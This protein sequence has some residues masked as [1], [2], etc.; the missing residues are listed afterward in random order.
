MEIGV[1]VFDVGGFEVG[2]SVGGLG[3]ETVGCV[4]LIPD[5]RDIFARF[6]Y[7]SSS[8]FLSVEDRALSVDGSS[9]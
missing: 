2:M 4:K 9:S 7:E 6:A 3:D 1:E 8:S 5:M